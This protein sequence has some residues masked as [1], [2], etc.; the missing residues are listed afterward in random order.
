MKL[1][2][3]LFVSIFLFTQNLSTQEYDCLLNK[4]YWTP[5]LEL[6]PKM[7]SVEYDNLN[8]SFY[9][10]YHIDKNE[11][12]IIIESIEFENKSIRDF[13]KDL[14]EFMNNLLI[15]FIKLQPEKFSWNNIYDENKTMVIDVIRKV[16]WKIIIGPTKEN[17]IKQTLMP[18]SPNICYYTYLT[19]N[20][21][22][23]SAT[24]NLKE[25]DIDPEFRNDRYKI[26]LDSGC[27]SILK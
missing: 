19:I 27:I 2:I 8:Y 4:G 17:K 25:Y 10:R 1:S 22:K 15:E 26:P 3:I 16:N 6:S 7:L 11:N 23:E 9:Y 21:N 12:K 5:E 14:R 18:C 24:L 13:S 20:Q